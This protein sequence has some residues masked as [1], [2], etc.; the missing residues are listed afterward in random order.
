MSRKYQSRQ[1]FS[2]K[3]LVEGFIGGR[4]IDPG[5]W[6]VSGFRFRVSAHL[7]AAEAYILGRPV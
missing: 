3:G 4:A 7:M 1:G 5:Q 6:K 2:R